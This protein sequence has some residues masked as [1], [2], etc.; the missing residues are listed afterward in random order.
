MTMAHRAAAGTLL[1]LFAAH[2]R[3]HF[4]PLGDTAAQRDGRPLGPPPPSPPPSPPGD[5]RPMTAPGADGGG[6]FGGDGRPGTAGVA[7][8]GGGGEK[9]LP[10]LS[11]AQANELLRQKSSSG[12][13]SPRGGR[14]LLRRRTP[15]TSASTTR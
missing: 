10:A 7:L 2:A 15:S 14:P 9:A 12:T 11:A 6:G 13:A 5:G 4:A 1:A 8:T 3:L